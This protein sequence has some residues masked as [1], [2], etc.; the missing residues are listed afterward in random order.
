MLPGS[1]PYK[2]DSKFLVL[3]VFAGKTMVDQL[4]FRDVKKGDTRTFE[5]SIPNKDKSTPIT[6]Q[7]L[8]TSSPSVIIG[9]KNLV[10][11]KQ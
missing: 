3:R 10:L 6:L 11:K 2:G 7:V 1:I 8:K 9:I 5:T 4:L